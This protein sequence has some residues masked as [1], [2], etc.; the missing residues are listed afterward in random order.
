M[1]PHHNQIARLGLKK[2]RNES[3]DTKQPKW[4]GVGEISDLDSHI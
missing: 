2:I 4:P 1:D 3:L